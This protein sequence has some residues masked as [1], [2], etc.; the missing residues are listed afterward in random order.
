[1]STCKIKSRRRT[2]NFVLEARVQNIQK[3][4]DHTNIVD[5]HGGAEVCFSIVQIWSFLVQEIRYE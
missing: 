3:L 1:M 4:I 5:A 2:S